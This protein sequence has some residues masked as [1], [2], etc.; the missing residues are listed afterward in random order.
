[1]PTKATLKA[2]LTQAPLN[3]PLVT[4]GPVLDDS[5]DRSTE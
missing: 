4:Q 3:I 2:L 5:L 1:M